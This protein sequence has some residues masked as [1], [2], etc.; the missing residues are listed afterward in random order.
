[1][2]RP[3]R[4]LYEH[5]TGHE[6]GEHLTLL[7]KCDVPICVHATAGADSHLHEGDTAANMRDR[8]LKGRRG[9][10]H[11]GMRGLA[12]SELARRSRALRA[13]VLE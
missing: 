13:V 8:E 10:G 6:R 12:R 11:P 9:G 5:V 3:Q 1:M 4:L 2:V 7:H